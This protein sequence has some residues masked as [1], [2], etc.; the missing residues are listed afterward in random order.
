MV[1][2]DILLKKL[3]L[4]KV[5]QT[6]FSWFSSY[7]NSRFQQTHVSGVN[8]ELKPVISGVPQGSILGPLLFLIFINDLPLATVHSMTDIFADDTT[9][10]VHSSSSKHVIDSLAFDLINVNSWCDLNRMYIN[11]AKTKLMIISSKQ[12]ANRIQHSL[13][14]I[15]LNNEKIYSSHE[16]LLGITLDKTLAWEKQV[17]IVL[18]KCN[19]L[20]YLLSRIKSFLSISQYEKNIC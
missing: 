7:L 8:S 9:L 11:V 13:P 1:D 18:K 10:S 14:S 2:H 12:N 3:K 4:Y 16:K 6:A 19:S 20:L 5:D 15:E 17:D